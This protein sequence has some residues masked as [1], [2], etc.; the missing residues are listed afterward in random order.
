MSRN[1]QRLPGGKRGGSG[2]ISPQ[3]AQP[4]QPTPPG[5]GLNMNGMGNFNLGNLAGAMNNS[6]F[7]NTAQTGTIPTTQGDWNDNGNPNVVKYQQQTDDKLATYLAGVYN[8]TDYSD[9]DDGKYGFYD[10]SYQKLVLKMGL[11]GKPTV[12]K[13]SDFNQLAQQTGAQVVYRGWSS[14]DSAD[15]FTNS[16]YFHVGNGFYGDGV[17]FTPDKTTAG[18]YGIGF[19]KGAITKMMLSPTARVVD[20]ADVRRAI[21]NT[22]PRLQRGLTKAGSSGSHSY[23]SNN[24]ESQMAIRMGYNVIRIN[25]QKYVAL[26]GDA[27]IVS[28]KKL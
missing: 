22:S 13:D 8:K 14:A 2:T 17:Y 16:K 19:G 3:P 27:F 28:D 6:P 15:R 23:G 11:N 20:I 18:A 4:A 5:R 12:M 1:K 26:T 24:G 9:Y 10:N 21:N 7:A 25:S